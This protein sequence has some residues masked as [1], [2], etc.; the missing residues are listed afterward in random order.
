MHEDNSMLRDVFQVWR[1]L[2]A[3]TPLSK[4]CW[5]VTQQVSV[6]KHHLVSSSFLTEKR[7]LEKILPQA[8]LDTELNVE[9]QRGGR[10]T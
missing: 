1:A 3:K 10:L 7:C 2:N 9:V 8:I 5:N 4:K 6:G